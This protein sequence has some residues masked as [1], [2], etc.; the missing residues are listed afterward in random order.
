MSTKTKYNDIKFFL[1]AIVCINAFNYYLTYNNIRFNSYFALTFCIDT[2]QGW[3]AW[4]FVRSIIIILDQKLPYTDNPLRRILVQLLLTCI[5]GLLVIILLTEL[6]SWIVKGRPA[7]TSFYL[8]DLFIILIWFIV[9][10]GIYVGMHYYTEWK[11]SEWKRQQEQKVRMGGYTVRQGKENLLISFDDMLSFYAEDGYIV[12]LTWQNRKYILDKSL[13]KIENV[14]PA[15]LF[16]RLNRQYI[17]HRNALTGFKRTGDGKIDVILKAG[18]NLP[19]A[20]PVSRTRAALFKSWF[21][22]D[23]L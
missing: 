10:N 23:E 18:D 22:P 12:L 5:T 2:V 4:W 21:Q 11:N 8:F 19:K 15:E 14:L 6:A 13:D 7:I 17:V 3:I 1:P 16:F 20:I 9:I